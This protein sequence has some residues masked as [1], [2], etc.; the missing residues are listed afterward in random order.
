MAA[1]EN[2]WEALAEQLIRQSFEDA[3][4]RLEA[5]EFALSLCRYFTENMESS[6][7]L[8]DAAACMQKNRDYYGRLCRRQ[9]GHGYH[10]LATGA[11]MAC[12]KALLQKT[13]DTVETISRRLDYS[14]ADYF[15]RV[16]KQHTGRT[17][18]QYRL[19]ARLEASAGTAEREP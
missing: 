9:T 4:I 10:E 18:G 13:D 6:L 5:N 11:R 14:T 16:F 1:R 2:S 15:S 17:P 3:G 19:Q 12:A 8:G 7:S